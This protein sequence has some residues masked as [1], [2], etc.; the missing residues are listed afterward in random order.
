M[1]QQHPPVPLR[2]DNRNNDGQ[3]SM[4]PLA[5]PSFLQ[6]KQTFMQQMQMPAP[7]QQMQQIVNPA[8]LHSLSANFGAQPKQQFTS[9]GFPGNIQLPTTFPMNTTT[10]TPNHVFNTPA[11][12][13]FGNNSNNNN[14]SSSAPSMSDAQFQ[15]LLA[16]LQK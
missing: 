9:P 16:S 7:L 8:N 15:E 3:S 2:A 12:A 5:S 10:S 11:H 1:Q 14:G 6:H 13:P 4:A